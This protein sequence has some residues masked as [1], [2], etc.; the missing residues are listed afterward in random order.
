MQTYVRISRTTYAR[1]LRTDANKK[2][3]IYMHNKP[4]ICIDIQIYAYI[5]VICIR[6]NMSLYAN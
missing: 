1:K 2:Y 5:C 6:V 3:A 4:K